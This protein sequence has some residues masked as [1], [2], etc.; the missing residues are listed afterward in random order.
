M[1]TRTLC[2]LFISNIMLYGQGYGQT[3]F[4]RFDPSPYF[5]F[6]T[7]LVLA[8]DGGYLLAGSI[9]EK[10]NSSG[11]GTKD[12]VIIK[13]DQEGNQ[14]WSTI[15]DYKWNGVSYADVQAK[16]IVN[17]D[18]TI[19]VVSS[20]HKNS[21]SVDGIL[22]FWTL[23]PEGDIV[24]HESSLGQYPVDCFRNH[25]GELITAGDYYSCPPLNT[26]D[27]YMSFY[28]FDADLNNLWNFNTI[29]TQSIHNSV[30]SA[31][32]QSPFHYSLFG[33]SFFWNGE[34][35]EAYLK[36]EVFNT[37]QFAWKSYTIDYTSGG[38]GFL[39][40]QTL[41]V[42]DQ[43][44]VLGYAVQSDYILKKFNTGTGGT[45]WTRHLDM[46]NSS[47]V[48]IS[49]TQDGGFIVTEKDQESIVLLR[50]D[51]DGYEVW[52]QVLPV[53]IPISDTPPPTVQVTSLLSSIHETTDGGFIIAGEYTP[54][55]AVGKHE[56]FVLKT[57]SI[58]GLGGWLEGN[59]KR[60][61][62]SNCIAEDF[63]FPLQG[64]I[65][66]AKSNTAS[67]FATTDS[68]GHYGH[69]L[70]PNN[71]LV[72]FESNE[73]GY[74]AFCNPIN[75]IE[76]ASSQD[77]VTVDQSIG[78]QESCPLM[79]IDIGTTNINACQL[80]HY[81]IQYCNYGTTGSDTASIVL[82]LD[83]YMEISGST[84]PYTQ[85]GNKALF[86]L[87]DIQPG[88]CGSIEI[89]VFVDC[90][91]PSGTELCLKGNIYPSLFCG[92]EDPP[93]GVRFVDLDCRIVG[94]PYDPNDKRCNPKGQGDA[95]LVLADTLLNYT[96]R[97]QNTG[98]DTATHVVI[99]DTLSSD[100]DIS[101]FEAGASSHP[102][103][104]SISG[105]RELKFSFDYI[106]LPDSSASFSGSQGYISYFIKP[107][108]PTIPGR[109][110]H[111][112]ASIYFDYQAPILTNTVFHT[113]AK[114]VHQGNVE[115]SL[116]E[117]EILDGM[118]VEKDT[119]LIDTFSFIWF[120]SIRILHLTVL[121]SYESVMS[122]SICAGE[123][124]SFDNGYLTETGTYQ[125]NN[126]TQ[127]GC[128]SIL[129][130]RLTVLGDIQTLDS[131]ILCANDTSYYTGFI[132]PV[133]GNYEEEVIFQSQMGCDSTI[134]VKVFVY[135]DDTTTIEKEFE[136]GTF[137]QGVQLTQD[138]VFIYFETTPF[139][140]LHTIIEEIT[141]KPTA[142]TDSE[143]QLDD[144]TIYPNPTT[145][146]LVVK[147][148]NDKVVIESWSIY[149]LDG[150][151]KLNS[152]ARI[153]QVGSE[154]IFKIPVHSL[155]VGMYVL[156]VIS[157]E[158]TIRSTFIKE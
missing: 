25:I 12:L 157:N 114:P 64:W 92:I 79:S 82:E 144:I 128:D 39:A 87:G 138:T 67:F 49:G 94:Q 134:Y 136:I 41:L 81:Q 24:S 60:D 62:N 66:E 74:W 119:V 140:C 65:V 47:S 55:W 37:D 38:A 26:C 95:N 63:E 14:Q 35:Y 158:I 155:P 34:E 143:K 101:T 116:C 142:I 109:K 85:N 42:D 88:D 141:V 9:N 96:I 48:L 76:I 104:W 20:T 33:Q 152:G 84:Y 102:Y 121:P 150:S 61:F 69:R 40:G 2:L 97:F 117:G 78:I 108:N 45:I 105:E 132:Y 100:F 137:Y 151:M 110:I 89:E 125:I 5:E 145:N 53:L 22:S 71:Y 28:V 10:P 148:M 126:T 86:Y 29:G 75:Q 118:F 59:V 52:R 80:N 57:D 23:T 122:D 4:K 83:A 153:F 46:A 19:L 7:D 50:L 147:S 99:R 68:N 30:F 112:N 27:D 77:T 133:A 123:S 72:I 107:K 156:N 98:M 103:N 149:G 130:L 120:D 111:N 31:L 90:S 58:G 113:I 51:T 154:Q 115:L 54:D 32:E 131:L 6:S 11:S 1:V 36:L 91:F 3:W 56:L 18:G 93:S 43:F 21:S 139:G 124:Y 73:P 8:P 135:Q 127:T 129:T 13:L 106:D 44:V 17:S 70:P 146:E 15:L 16:L